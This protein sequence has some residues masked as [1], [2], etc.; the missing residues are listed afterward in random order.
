MEAPNK[1]LLPI[2]SV[3][4]TCIADSINTLYIKA[5]VT[6]VWPYSSS[7]K[8]LSVLL[9]EPDFRLRRNKGQVRV[10]FKGACA[11]AV[12][13]SRLTSNDEV[14]LALESCELF[15]EAN[16]NVRNGTSGRSVGWEIVIRKRLELQV[17]RGSQEPIQISVQED[18][19]V[20]PERPV[21]PPAEV[22]APL[23][24]APWLQTWRSP[25]FLK[26]KAPG[27]MLFFDARIVDESDDP[28]AQMD[29]DLFEEDLGRIKRPRFSKP[30]EGYRFLSRSPSPVSEKMAED[31]R[32]EE[33]EARRVSNGYTE[34]GTQIGEGELSSINGSADSMDVSAG[35]FVQDQPQQ[36]KEVAQEDL[37]ATQLP[38]NSSPPPEA[39]DAPPDPSTDGALLQTSIEAS[40]ELPD[41][42][43]L[44]TSPGTVSKEVPSSPILPE[45]HDIRNTPPHM[46]DP[47]RSPLRITT[48]AAT[49][50]PL[51]HQ[52][53]DRPGIPDPPRIEPVLSPGLPL[54]SPLTDRKSLPMSLIPPETSF[55]GFIPIN[56]AFE[57]PDVVPV[58]PHTEPGMISYDIDDNTTLD[59]ILN[60]IKT[61]E[62]H[63]EGIS[64]A[65]F[66]GPISETEE[67]DAIAKTDQKRLETRSFEQILTE[68][69]SSPAEFTV[70]EYETQSFRPSSFDRDQTSSFHLDPVLMEQPPLFV[71]EATVQDEPEV[72]VT[73]SSPR[74]FQ[75]QIIAL[76]SPDVMKAPSEA[77]DGYEPGKP[78]SQALPCDDDM[79]DMSDDSDDSEVMRHERD[80]QLLKREREENLSNPRLG[81]EANF[82]RFADE[83][84]ELPP[85]TDDE[86]VPT[87]SALKR[88]KSS[89]IPDSLEDDDEDDDEIPSMADSNEDD[90]EEE[91]DDSDVSMNSY[92]VMAQE[93]MDERERYKA[94]YPGEELSSE[95]V[96][97][98]DEEDE[99]I[100]EIEEDEEDEDEDE[101]DYEDYY[102]E[103]PDVRPVG[104]AEIS[105]PVNPLDVHDGKVKPMLSPSPQK[106]V[107]KNNDM[108]QPSTSNANIL[109]EDKKTYDADVL[110]SEPRISE[111]DDYESKVVLIDTAAQ[112]PA[113]VPDLSNHDS[114]MHPL[115]T[116]SQSSLGSI[117]LRDDERKT[118]VQ[119]G[120]SEITVG[121]TASTPNQ[122]QEDEEHQESTETPS[123]SAQTVEIID[124]EE[125]SEEDLEQIE[126]PHEDQPMRDPSDD[127]NDNPSGDVK[128]EIE[129][130]KEEAPEVAE[131]ED[132][133]MDSND[134]WM[135]DESDVEELI[136]Y[137]EGEYE[138]EEEDE[139]DDGEEGDDAIE[140]ADEDEREPENDGSPSDATKRFFEKISAQAI[141][142]T[143]SQIEPP[144]TPNIPRP[145]QERSFSMDGHI[146][147][148]ANSE[149]VKMGEIDR[150]W[151]R[152]E[153]V[154]HE[155]ALNCTKQESPQI[156]E[157]K[158]AE[159]TVQLTSTTVLDGTDS[160]PA[161]AIVGNINKAAL[162]PRLKEELLTPI[163]TQQLDPSLKM[164]REGD[165]EEPKIIV[166]PPMPFT[167]TPD[168][169]QP[170]EVK[171]ET[172]A[173]RE[174]GVKHEKSIIPSN[175]ELSQNLSTYHPST[176]P[177]TIPPLQYSLEKDTEVLSDLTDE[178]NRQIL[179]PLKQEQK[180]VFTPA[181][182]PLPFS[183]SEY[184]ESDE[185]EGREEDDLDTGE[186]EDRQRESAIAHAYFD[187]LKMKRSEDYD[188]PDP[189]S[190]RRDIERDYES[191]L[192]K[193]ELDYDPRFESSPPQPRRMRSSQKKEK[194]ATTKLVDISD[195]L[196]TSHGYYPTLS[197]LEQHFETT[198]STLAVVVNATIPTRAALGPRDWFLTFYLLD[199]TLMRNGN[200]G[201]NRVTKYV[202]AQIFRPYKEA[203]P[204]IREGDAVL[205][206]NFKV[207][208]SGRISTGKDHIQPDLA[209]SIHP[210]MLL[211]TDS[212]AWAV[213]QS[214]STTPTQR[215]TARIKAGQ[216]EH[217]PPIEY[218]DEEVARVQYLQNWWSTRMDHE[219]LDVMTRQVQQ[220]VKN[221]EERAERSQAK[222]KAEAET[223]KVAGAN[224][225][226]RKTP[227]LS[228]SQNGNNSGHKS[229]RPSTPTTPSIIISHRQTRSISARLNSQSLSPVSARK[230]R[231]GVGFFKRFGSSQSYV[232]PEE[233]DA[234]SV[235]ELRDG[236]RYRDSAELVERRASDELDG[237]HELRDGTQWRD[238]GAR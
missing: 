135:V 123:A 77:K 161:A 189:I 225:V 195:A 117:F 33:L 3:S 116:E 226:Y 84:V 99:E 61:D 201:G 67:I 155:I 227:S 179:L 139:D 138:E 106:D 173:L 233:D 200:V 176:V 194:M 101:E 68:I 202:R 149:T 159:D 73:E 50:E 110:H 180:P 231:A 103:D 59:E 62:I 152:L 153:K 114:G 217:G 34:H 83:L 80:D 120:D 58:Q 158:N 143:Q 82:D 187:E 51:L 64:P 89:T 85:D 17:L 97:E 216:A 219:D 177:E 119:R 208:S 23:Q 107:I 209:K 124:L 204:R 196:R 115:P 122:G 129:T 165:N 4:P 91:E 213:F 57:G 171:N 175:L 71:T 19:P 185:E 146:D 188:L 184:T 39:S 52:D 70:P 9:V 25:A 125:D 40:A 92:D 186:E 60:E 170:T 47:P 48:Q 130:V 44:T 75:S 164:E 2:S 54:V 205:L 140:D 150:D 81:G 18:A 197:I 66:S 211:S 203:L 29:A 72:E 53:T 32:R 43:G 156:G 181:K 79:D 172:P 45:A 118:E 133:E 166:A 109:D 113:D 16:D 28:F 229:T 232:D 134:D 198:T 10:T 94:E 8:S 178:A 221:D 13:E 102:D 93:A 210:F 151:V 69:P 183:S 35:E 14:V 234:N 86:E 37:H 169:S 144:S 141:A 215:S 90:E 27:A 21:F 182:Y 147:I 95:E 163:A 223:K 38:A 76:G 222:A 65:P 206:R 26:R 46:P 136:E 11:K 192:D 126:K 121:N 228:Q 148:L 218:G 104:E 193:E 87:S 236:T 78:F 160:V 5:V 31:R 30:G 235:H 199:T 42:A 162:D 108:S 190:R 174:A 20:S 127:E 22:P 128:E 100:E 237:L 224:Q 131:D 12:E 214:P 191:D 105:K 167:F 154:A 15:A 157:L 111:G 112:V 56:I 36:N 24:T 132:E 238:D 88:A 137:E 7:S 96:S 55:G 49:P 168:E 207:Q 145:K 142:V 6:L 98:E 1:T 63:S 230:A 41:E 212:S 220:L 74:S